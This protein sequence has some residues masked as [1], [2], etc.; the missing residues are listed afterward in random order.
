MRRAAA[1][2]LVLLLAGC[3]T[4]PPVVPNNIPLS[5][6]QIPAWTAS[7]RLALFASGTGGAGN[8]IWN[9]AGDDLQLGIR[10]PLGVGALEIQSS[11][12]DLSLRDGTG[13]ALDAEDARARLEE[14]LGTDLPLASLRYWMLG[15]PAPGDE[16]LVT[17]NGGSASRV[18]EQSG[19]RVVYQG[20]KELAGFS[21]P[22]RISVD[23]PGVRLKLII[24][25]WQLAA[26]GLAPGG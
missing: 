8:F 15:I 3:A 4:V 13:Q 12:Q 7:G 23:R 19:W 14:R 2:I 11:G 18:I 17:D 16:A 22:A 25:T 26:A 20:F 5:A 21:L 1:F 9:Q 24:D 10:G 6:D